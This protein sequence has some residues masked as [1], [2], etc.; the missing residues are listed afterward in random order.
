MSEAI[1][2]VP[3]EGDDRHILVVDNDT[4]LVAEVC[5]NRNSQH[6][7]GFVIVVAWQFA[8]NHL[9]VLLQRQFDRFYDEFV[10]DLQDAS[11]PRVDVQRVAASLGLVAAIVRVKIIPEIKNDCRL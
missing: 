8:I 2:S 4:R 5:G 6:E 1:Q 11:I 10:A 3:V 9:S 7:A